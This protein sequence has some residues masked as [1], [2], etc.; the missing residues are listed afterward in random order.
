MNVFYVGKLVQTS[1]IDLQENR[2]NYL[3]KLNL[4]LITDANCQMCVS[5]IQII[6]LKLKQKTTNI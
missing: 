1:I 5:C 2:F 3:N 4:N 6:L